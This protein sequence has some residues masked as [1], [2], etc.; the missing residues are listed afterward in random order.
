VTIEDHVTYS[1]DGSP[2]VGF[3]VVAKEDPPHGGFLHRRESSE[4]AHWCVSDTILT[5]ESVLMDRLTSENPPPIFDLDRSLI[6]SRGD[7]ARQVIDSFLNSTEFGSVDVILAIKRAPEHLRKRL[8]PDSWAR[9]FSALAKGDDVLFYISVLSAIVIKLPDQ[10]EEIADKLVHLLLPFLRG[11][12]NEIYEAAARLAGSVICCVHD[13]DDDLR[14]CMQGLIEFN[15]NALIDG[16]YDEKVCAWQFFQSVI[17]MTREGFF[18]LVS[19]EIWVELL[20]SVMNR[21]DAEHVD[22]VIEREYARDDINQG[23]S[24]NGD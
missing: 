5:V 14:E 20:E 13:I 4:D 24:D 21:D 22:E 23:S 7:A 12:Q 11:D 3:K 9:L 17:T 15:G 8:C 6:P 1:M 18:D 10:A 2:K 16:D 19:E